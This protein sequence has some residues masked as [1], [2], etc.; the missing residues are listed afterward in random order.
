MLATWSPVVDGGYLEPY[1]SGVVGVEWWVIRDIWVNRGMVGRWIGDIG[2]ITGAMGVWM[3]TLAYGW[4]MGYIM[5]LHG[6]YIVAYGF[7]WAYPVGYGG[8]VAVWVGATSCGRLGSWGHIGHGVEWMGRAPPTPLRLHS[9]PPQWATANPARRAGGGGGRPPLVGGAYIGAIQISHG[10]KDPHFSPRLCFAPPI[11]PPPPAG[12]RALP[13]ALKCGAVSL[14]PVRGGL[15]AHGPSGPPS[16]RRGSYSPPPH[17]PMARLHGSGLCGGG[18]GV[19]TYQYEGHVARVFNLKTEY[20][21]FREVHCL[22]P[23]TMVPYTG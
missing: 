6:Y 20:S 11:G 21:L 12:G 3:P 8:S 1:W 23:S 4:Y 10:P 16:V 15:L 7:Q 9:K 17:V 13:P 14:P 19:G 2:G 22:P 18:I 5:G